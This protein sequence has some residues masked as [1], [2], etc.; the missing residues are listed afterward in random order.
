MHG[1]TLMVRENGN[2]IV[3]TYHKGQFDLNAKL[4]VKTKALISKIVK[5]YKYLIGPV[6]D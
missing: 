3:T 4:S 2:S 1:D 6:G 5:D